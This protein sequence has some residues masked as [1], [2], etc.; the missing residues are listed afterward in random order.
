MIKK[1]FQ[2]NRL[3]KQIL[4]HISIWSVFI[5]FNLM[6]P[7]FESNI[8]T[9]QII[10]LLIGNMVLFYINYS[11]LVTHFLLKNKTGLYVSC[12]VVLIIISSIIFKEYVPEFKPR[13][14]DLPPFPDNKPEPILRFKL[15]GPIAFNILLVVTGTALRV[16]TEWNRN[17]R[18]KKEIEVQKSSTELHFLKHQLSPHF[19]FNS[20]NS[21]Y[22]L[23]TKKSNDAP[24][25]VITLS[26]LMRYMLYETNNEFVP[27][28]S[29]LH[30]IQ[31]YLKL[32]RLR[33]ANNENVTLN[34]HGSILNQKIRPLLLISFIENAFKYGTDFKGN[35]EVKIEI[36]ILGNELQFNCINLIGNRKT[37]KDSSG[38]G[39]QNTKERLE[40]LYPEKHELLIAESPNKFT[41]N[42]TLKL[43]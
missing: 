22:S 26:E 18:K 24:E 13:P 19:L 32:Q 41:V 30:Y 38:I 20:L 29:E 14:N 31:N 4:L 6:Q 17:E 28:K 3:Q 5:V 39:L 35:T 15:I 34:I 43:D 9:K 21:I 10:G 27:L 8:I 11:Y 37:D 23:T 7:H 1:I 2:D 16:Y 36:N 12:I 40:L 25:A 33:I 42:L